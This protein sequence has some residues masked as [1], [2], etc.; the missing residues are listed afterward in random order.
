[1]TQTGLTYQP[2]TSK[3]G[4]AAGNSP[5]FNIKFWWL[6]L[7]AFSLQWVTLLVL[8]S[9]SFVEVKRGMVVLSYL[10]LLAALSRN[11]HSWGLRLVII[12]T[13]L[14][15][16]AI[17][18]NGGL[19][20]VSPESRVA[21]HGVAAIGSYG[22]GDILPRSET[23]ILPVDQMRLWFL[24]D[25]IPVASFHRVVSVG[26]IVI[27]GGLFGFFIESI[28]WATTCSRRDGKHSDCGL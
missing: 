21:A 15:F 11:L 17:A 27:V 24:S 3:S 8:P 10:L 13:M 22:I 2:P 5:S 23:I 19:M 16:A 4:L 25:V 9:S 28:F 7:F 18:A 20:P 6:I 26:D 12:G 1:M 14:N